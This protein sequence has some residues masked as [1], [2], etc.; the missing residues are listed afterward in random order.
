VVDV[1]E[2]L[3]PFYDRILADSGE[4]ALFDVHTHIGANDPDGYSQRPDELLG[5]LERAAARAAV[6]P[7]HEPGGYP[8]ANDAVLEA[9]AEAGDRLV[10]FC[11]V[12]PRDG[13]VAEATRCLDAGARGIKLHPRAEQFAL[14]EPA[15]RELVALAHDRRVPVLIHAGRGIP[16]L[17]QDTV[18]LSGEF[19]G[20][21]L[22]LAH[23]AISDI[24]WLWRVM[25][26]HPNVF[27]DTSWWNP[28]DLI[29]LFSLAP[30][31]QVLF[32]SDSPYGSP[33]SGAVI[34]LRCALQAGLTPEA[35]R[36]VA[37]A[38]AARLV[39]GEEPLDAGPPPGPPPPLDPLLE[40][41]VS[42]IVA[43]LGRIF[44]R[45]D[46]E[47]SVGLARLSCAVGEEADGAEVF[48]AVLELLDLY[49][50]HVGDPP[51]A[52]RPFPLTVRFL[53]AALILARTPDVPL[54]PRPDAPPP[55]RAEAEQA[56][57]G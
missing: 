38:Q 23:A 56:A 35:L 7:M 37:G 10:P 2:I 17:G 57:Q 22:I 13:A 43:A 29:A 33:I 27:V 4:L 19:P 48:S 40:R 5:A 53:V 11:R 24:A 50:A 39:A 52:G 42:H 18:R 54:P 3:R 26:E 15:V 21:R 25:P 41:V 45:T 34:A 6:F 46:A 32:A 31:G 12:D 51:P 44:G 14:S 8:A 28:A 49:D 9:A 1:D 20:A 30:P 47:E 16:A 36:C 55:T